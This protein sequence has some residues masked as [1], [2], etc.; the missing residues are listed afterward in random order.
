MKIKSH[1]GCLLNERADGYADL[2]QSAEGLELCPGPQKHGSLWL[3]V[4]HI[5]RD[6]A[7]QSKKEHYLCE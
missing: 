4:K 2:G 6:Y 7:Q 1:I 3:R 5:V